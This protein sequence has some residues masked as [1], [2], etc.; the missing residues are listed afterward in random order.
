MFDNTSFVHKIKL[1]MIHSQYKKETPLFKM[2]FDKKF[3]H[4]RY[5]AISTERKNFKN[6]TSFRSSIFEKYNDFKL[7]CLS[8]M[9]FESKSINKLMGSDENTK[10]DENLDLD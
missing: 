4:D 7:D 9:S 8:H 1:I 6:R 5:T 10:V 3:R 2:I